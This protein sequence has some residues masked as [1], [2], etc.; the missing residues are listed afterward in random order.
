[1]K[2]LM[3]EL[4]KDFRAHDPSRG[5]PNQSCPMYYTR[6]SIC[7]QHV[8]WRHSRATRQVTALATTS[9]YISI[10]SNAHARHLIV[11]TSRVHTIEAHTH[12]CI[13]C[14]MHTTRP[15]PTLTHTLVTNT[16]HLQTTPGPYS[17][18]H[19]ACPTTLAACQRT[20]PERRRSA[21]QPLGCGLSW[22]TYRLTRHSWQLPWA[23]ADT[24]DTRHAGG[25][26]ARPHVCAIGRA[27]NKGGTVPISAL[28]AH[29]TSG[30]QRHA[31]PMAAHQTLSCRLQDLPH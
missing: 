7:H 8:H 22:P 3:G 23:H 10:L 9:M 28:D 25:V 14:D 29:Y 15:P 30:S 24:A 5:A 31:C 26:A 11:H 27:K 12:T 17:S 1:M 2:S 16:V 13:V 20:S 6:T 21:R 4:I 19:H 18:R